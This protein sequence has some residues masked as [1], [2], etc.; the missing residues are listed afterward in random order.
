M[1]KA[2]YLP[3]F[4]ILQ[5]LNLSAQPNKVWATYY[6]DGHQFMETDASSVV[7][8]S[9]GFIYVAGYTFDSSIN[10][11]TPNSFRTH[12]TGYLDGYL[13]KFDTLGNRIWATYIGNDISATQPQI[14][15]DP[16]GNILLVDFTTGH[17]NTIATPG[18]FQPNLPI[19][20]NGNGSTGYLIKFDKDG[21]RLWG[22]YLFV[23]Q[24]MD[25]NPA[26]F[27]PISVATD[28]LGNILVCGSVVG[29]QSFPPSNAF[30]PT[31]TSNL[32]TNGFVMKFSPTGSFLW[33]TYYGGEG[34]DELSYV[35]CNTANEIYLV[36]NTSSTAGI[37]SAN[38]SYPIYT[39]NALNKES[40]VVKL[41]PDGSRAWG[42]Y[43]NGIFV[44][45]GIA[46]DSIG[47]FYLAG[48][49][50][51][52]TGIATPN[53]YQTNYAGNS[54]F[55]LSHWT[56]N[57][58]KNWGTYYG[59]N[60]IE[61]TSGLSSGGWGF[62]TN[63]I[64]LDPS[65][66]ILIVGYTKSHENIRFGCTYVGS[67]NDAEDGY[68][69][70]A[71]FYPDGNIMWGSYYDIYINAVACANKGSSFYVVSS[72]WEDSLSTVGSFQPSKSNGMTA[73]FISKME[74]DFICPV[75]QTNIL[76]DSGN[77]SINSGYLNYQWYHNGTPLSGGNSSGYLA[78]DTGI[79]W[80]T[81]ESSCDCYYT[82]D[83]V[84]VTS[85]GETGIG[86]T[87]KNDLNIN[88]Y[89][90]PN[91][92]MFSLNGAFKIPNQKL[93]F[94]LSDIMGKNIFESTIQ[95]K[96]AKLNRKFDFSHLNPGI[97]IIN[98]KSDLGQSVLRL[99]KN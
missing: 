44:R 88:L 42:T 72:T 21:N 19:L 97:Y 24:N 95:I 77:L 17:Q 92:G 78:I 15:L 3:L 5:S 26:K 74:G 47:G 18:S 75:L 55:C 45:G 86:S 20:T 28:N 85:K 61:S 2:I 33:G 81:F 93:N 90:N 91:N 23:D 37:A 32:S 54:D 80:V 25:L 69:F 73:G 96:G 8:D 87:Y 40:F 41:N 31:I 53:T 29:M 50:S 22:T 99:I 98:V 70:I 68:G 35:V 27:S 48:T 6:G 11:A 94:T 36:G 46:L 58:V 16:L 9:T 52:D 66:N 49:T 14:T 43:T 56:S 7:Y 12:Q 63:S 64:S 62:K 59:G 79:Y 71:K 84:L 39:G 83:T 82:S 60:G 4:L 34:Y 76:N 51:R 57:G 65:G 89:P 13:A 38:A 67:A 30:M 10:L 1:K